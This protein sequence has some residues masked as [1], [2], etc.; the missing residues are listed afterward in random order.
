MQSLSSGIVSGIRHRRRR[1]Q[2]AALSAGKAL[3]RFA[4]VGE[5]QQYFQPVDA[6]GCAVAD[7][8]AVFFSHGP[9]IGKADPVFW[10]GF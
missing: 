1:V 7:C 8:A 5:D 6:G 10:N 3:G 9:D 2:A 4:G